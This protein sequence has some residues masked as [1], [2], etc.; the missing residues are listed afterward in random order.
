LSAADKIKDAK[1]EPVETAS[2]I[3]RAAFQP[4]SAFCMTRLLEGVKGDATPHSSNCSTCQ[5]SGIG[6]ANFYCSRVAVKPSPFRDQLFEG[7]IALVSPAL[8]LGDADMSRDWD[9]Y[10]LGR[11]R[12]FVVA[13]PTTSIRC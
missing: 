13:Q 6:C 12:F 9:Q 4:I 1:A 7:R 8:A 2:G 3:R 11:D 5:A 10:V